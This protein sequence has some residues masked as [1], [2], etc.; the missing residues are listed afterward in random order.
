[1]TDL[2]IEN[3]HECLSC[4]WARFTHDPHFLSISSRLRARDSDDIEGT[5][6][7]DAEQQKI[8]IPGGELRDWV[9]VDHRTHLGES[10]LMWMDLQHKCRTS[11][12]V[13]VLLR[14]R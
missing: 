7:K 13:Q 11:L 12:I 3:D 8:A 2:R 1:M 5:E 10:N 6:M 9:L 14:R 4:I